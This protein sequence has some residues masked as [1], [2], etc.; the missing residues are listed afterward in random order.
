MAEVRFATSLF[1]FIAVFHVCSAAHSNETWVSRRQPQNRND[2]KHNNMTLF[3]FRSLVVVTSDV[4][5]PNTEFA[6]Y[7]QLDQLNIPMRGDPNLQISIE[8]QDLAHYRV[9]WNPELRPATCEFII[10]V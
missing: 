1:L 3:Y 9:I 8:I 2:N 7:F 4:I 10:F 6:V 5:V